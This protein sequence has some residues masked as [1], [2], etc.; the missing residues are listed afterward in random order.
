MI[1]S[2]ALSRSA[3]EGELGIVA[4][5]SIEEASKRKKIS[6]S[7]VLGLSLLAELKSLFEMIV[8]S[9]GK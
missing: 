6:E 4:V 9:K 5:D 7:K 1:F 3:E 2:A 8:V